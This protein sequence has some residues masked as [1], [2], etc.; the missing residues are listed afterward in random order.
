MASDS[1]WRPNIDEMEEDSPPPIQADAQSRYP[2]PIPGEWSE[3]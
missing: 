3:I 1:Q 2:V